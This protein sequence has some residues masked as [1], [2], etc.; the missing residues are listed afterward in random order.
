MIFCNFLQQARCASSRS[1]A[2]ES[3]G[4]TNKPSKHERVAGAGSRRHRARRSGLRVSKRKARGGE[5]KSQAVPGRDVGCPQ[6]MAG[7]PHTT[8]F[9][10]SKPF[11]SPSLSR[12]IPPHRPNLMQVQTLQ[13]R[14]HPSA[15]VR[16]GHRGDLSITHTPT[17][18]AHHGMHSTSHRYVSPRNHP[19]Q[20]LLRRAR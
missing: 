12:Y 13:V 6:K 14:V 7:C 15:G 19:P 4:Y 1:A 9:L 5:Q 11:V 8:V 18:I 2:G 17:H 16:L 3:I 10:R 20:H